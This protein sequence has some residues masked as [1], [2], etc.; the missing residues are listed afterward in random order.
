MAATAVAEPHPIR[1]WFE[2]VG[3]DR[4]RLAATSPPNAHPIPLLIFNGIGASV[5]ILEPF[6]RRMTGFRVITFDLPGV[7][8]SK[9][10]AL[11]RRMPDFARLAIEVLDAIGVERVFVMGISWGGGLAQQFAHD[12]P[13]RSERLVLAATSTG[14]LMVPPSLPVMIHMS[15]PLRYLSAAYFKRIAG[16]IYG[17]DFRTDKGLTDRYTRLMAPPSVLGYIN[18]LYAMTG[19]TSIFWAHRIHQPTL[20]MA[21]EDDPI[22]RLSNARLLNSLIP[23]SRLEVF[24]CGHLFLL[25]RLTKSVAS[26]Q[27]FLGDHELTD[28]HSSSVATIV[29]TS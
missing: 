19:W 28:A 10:T 22:I 21:G 27:R 15:T 11:A 9:N 5:E 2:S 3:G 23:N 26:V 6:M 4:I 24:D 1:H 25:T 17:G 16:T 18:Q 13:D 7:G 8:A 14:H 12:H 20:I 29:N